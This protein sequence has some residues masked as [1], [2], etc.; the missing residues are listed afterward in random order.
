MTFVVGLD[1]PTLMQLNPI[2]RELAYSSSPRVL[3]ALRPQDPIP[4]WITHTMY[5]GQP[6]T[7]THQG[8]KEAISKALAAEVATELKEIHDRRKEEDDE[9]ARLEDIPRYNSEFGR[10]LVDEG[11]VENPDHL[12]AKRSRIVR[13]GLKEYNM[14]A[15]TSKTMHSL[16]LHG[17]IA[18][19]DE[20]YHR[21]QLPE[22]P[23][24]GEP[25]IEMDGVVVKYGDTAV[26]GKWNEQLSLKVKPR[27]TLNSTMFEPYLEREIQS[28]KAT[29]KT[30]LRWTV[31]RGQRWALIGPNGKMSISPRHTAHKY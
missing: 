9:T 28:Q 19:Q 11:I 20:N 17:R 4:N 1:P 8:P 30:G 7:I 13:Q 18:L 31:R 2:L 23:P 25:L 10:T 21:R 14:G 3:L 5:L 24:V 26:L 16:G 6:L 15:R 27:R 12:Q 29:D 22:A